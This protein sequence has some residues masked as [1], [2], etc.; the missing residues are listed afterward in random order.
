[1]GNPGAPGHEDQ[2]SQAYALDVLTRQVR[3]N[4]SAQDPAKVCLG[5][6]PFAWNDEWWKSGNPSQHDTDGFA[7]AIYMN[8]HATEGGGGW[9]TSRARRARH[10]RRCKRSILE[11]Q[12]PPCEPE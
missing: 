4:L 9:S 3:A 8:R 10:T 2:D 7:G 11:P 1:V 12:D 6:T 5:G